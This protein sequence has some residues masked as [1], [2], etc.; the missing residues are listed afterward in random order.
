MATLIGDGFTTMSTPYGA[1]DM[2]APE[3]PTTETQDF[4]SKWVMAIHRTGG[5]AMGF[6]GPLCVDP[7]G[8]IP[9]NKGA[10][11]PWAPTAAQQERGR[12][13]S[14]AQGLGRRQPSTRTALATPQY[15]LAA[16]PGGTATNGC[17]RRGGCDLGETRTSAQRAWTAS[18]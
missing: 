3:S 18:R 14:A 5:G 17:L 16:V 4:I 12:R 13:E 1:N 15:P 8:S 7:V 9:A 2:T 10:G 11:A 6:Y